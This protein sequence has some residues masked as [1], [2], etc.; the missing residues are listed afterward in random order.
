[1]TNRGRIMFM[2]KWKPALLAGAMLIVPAQAFAAPNKEAPVVVFEPSQ[3]KPETIAETEYNSEA[4]MADAKAKMQKEIDEAIKLI[5]KIFGTDKLPPVAPGQLALAQTTTTALIPPGS[6]E[7]MLDNLYGKL[8]KGLLG[9]FG[10]MSDVMLSIK[11]GVDSEKIATLDEKS[12]TAI[13]DLF[14]PYRKQREDQLMT[15]VKPLISEAL[16]DLEGPM[17]NGLAHAYARKFTSA[18][19][20]EMNAFFATPTGKAYSAEWMALQAD[21]EVML[22]MIKAVPPLVGKFI[23]RGPEI[24]G[25]FKALPKEKQLTDMS[26]VELAK[27]A[28]LMK[29]DVKTLKENRDAWNSPPVEASEDWGATDAAADAAAADVADA[30]AAAADAAGE[31]IDDPAFDRENWSAADRTRVEQ[32]EEAASSA[33]SAA[34]DAQEAAIAN[35]RKK[36]S[37]K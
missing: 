11:T 7:K 6:L 12:K 23:D 27:L 2:S 22:A 35:A 33:A 25:K 34:Y 36:P 32:L 14:D 13:A 4:A 19:L 26:D 28:K 1:M 15:V 5:E 30:A 21:P 20:G 37:G 18:Q 24:E 29:V 17:R 10:G 9:E 16:S 8:F 3:T 31:A